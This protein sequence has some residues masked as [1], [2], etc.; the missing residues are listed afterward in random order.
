MMIEPEMT[1]QEVREQ[2]ERA[3]AFI[4]QFR[5]AVAD[6]IA[7]PA[8]DLEQHG[9]CLRRISDTLDQVPFVTF[10]NLSNLDAAWRNRLHMPFMSVVEAYLM[11]AGGGPTLDYADATAFLAV[12]EGMVKQAR[13][14]RLQ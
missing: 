9:E 4:A 6:A 7:D 11:M 5:E 3:E 10:C 14:Q 12:F 8:F 13:R 2:V 1:D